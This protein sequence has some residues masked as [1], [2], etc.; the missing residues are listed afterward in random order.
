LADTSA[1]ITILNSKSNTT[2][3]STVQCQDGA[4]LDYP[5]T[6]LN[7]I[8]G[9]L[10][11]NLDLQYKSGVYM[12]SLKDFEDHDWKMDWQTE[13]TANG[14]LAGSYEDETI[15]ADLSSSPVLMKW[16]IES[17]GDSL[18]VAAG[19]F[20]NLIKVKRDISFN[21]SN[22]HTYIENSEVNIPTTLTINTDLWYAP[23]IGMV[24][25][26]INSAS[27]KVY[28]LSFPI[29]VYGNYELQSYSIQ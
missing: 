10:S 25:Q 2:T 19:K 5:M 3:Q 22:L 9:M 23:E 8:M 14:T 13:Y 1:V 16:H 11:G 6:E 4:I 15:T 18:D 24:K 12:P 26:E 17:T 7:M 29:D 20:D 21:I 28:G 27:I